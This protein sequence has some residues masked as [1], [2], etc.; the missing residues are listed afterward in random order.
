MWKIMINIDGT[1]QKKG[2]LTV[3]GVVIYCLLNLCLES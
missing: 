1:M 3:L 2:I